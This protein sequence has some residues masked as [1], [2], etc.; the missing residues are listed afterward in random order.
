MHMYV[1]YMRFGCL[2]HMQRGGS[3]CQEDGPWQDT[4]SALLIPAQHLF[5]QFFDQGFVAVG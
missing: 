1:A 5:H 2:T 3:W 4:F